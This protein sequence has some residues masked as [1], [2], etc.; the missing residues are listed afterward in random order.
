[1]GDLNNVQII[2][3]FKYNEKEFVIFL[4]DEKMHFFYKHDNEFKKDFTDEEKMVLT[5][6]AD[7]ICMHKDSLKNCG[8]YTIGGQSIRIYLDIT[9]NFYF[10]EAVSGFLKQ[11]TLVSLNNYFNSQTGNHYLIRKSLN[12]NTFKRFLLISGALITLTLSSGC[13]IRTTPKDVDID[14]QGYTIDT[15]ESEI[16]SSEEM[17]TEEKKKKESSESNPAEI[18]EKILNSIDNNPNLSEKEKRFCYLLEDEIGENEKYIDEYTIPENMENLQI[19]YNELD[20]DN[21]DSNY[22][23][24]G[25]YNDI[26]HKV[27]LYGYNDYDKSFKTSN[28]DNSD[29]SSLFHE[30]NHALS[31]PDF[32]EETTTYDTLD[33]NTQKL[34]SKLYYGSDTNQWLEGYNELF[35]R[36]YYNSATGDNPTEAYEDIMPI[37]YA[38]SEIFSEDTI[39]KFKFDPDYS[40]L[41]KDLLQYD[42]DPEKAYEFLFSLNMGDYYRTSIDDLSYSENYDEDELSECQEEYNKNNK[43]LH[44]LLAYY[45]EK[46]YGKS[47]QE[48]LNILAYLHNTKYETSE[49]SKAFNN[50]FEDDYNDVTVSPKGYVSF[51]YK[52]EHSNSV[53]NLYTDDGVEKFEIENDSK[54]KAYD[55]IDGE[56]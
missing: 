38:S 50:S 54:I 13:Y 44:D 29:K 37:I 19:I 31:K 35:S 21:D 8:I 53:V 20:S 32:T 6:V 14:I 3:S 2:G 18:T 26:T 23:S 11:N 1:M 17:S 52:K 12:K 22:I 25:S 28:L 33:N 27:E 36:E 51:D 56:R 48:D 9:T 5:I 42:S 15:E 16:V 30:L 55:D 34:I 43:K 10:F 46:K 49:D 24:L 4:I 41:V 45:Y 40:Y 39:R 7:S 47:M